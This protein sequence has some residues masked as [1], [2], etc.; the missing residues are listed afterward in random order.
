MKKFLL[1]ITMFLCM[2]PTVFG[3][4]Y[5]STVEY[6]SYSLSE[7]S[8]VLSLLTDMD[9]DLSEYSNTSELNSYILNE[10]HG[11]FIISYRPSATSDDVFP[12]FLFNT[13]GKTNS[14]A[15]WQY[16]NYYDIQVLMPYFN[17][18][19]NKMYVIDYKNNKVDI[20]QYPANYFDE[21][22]IN[23]YS[24]VG[25]KLKLS[26]SGV[27]SDEF[28]S[29]DYQSRMFFDF[30][31]WYSGAWYGVENATS[32][33][34]SPTTS[35]PLNGK[36]IEPEP[37]FTPDTI[38][39]A[40]GYL[41]SPSAPAGDIEVNLDYKE[42]NQ[43]IHGEHFIGSALQSTFVFYYYSGDD[44]ISFNDYVTRNA[45]LN[46]DYGTWYDFYI[47]PQ[48]LEYLPNN[49]N[50]Y[51][52]IYATLGEN[53]ATVVK[54]F[55]AFHTVDN[56]SGGTG[57]DTE[58]GDTDENIQENIQNGIVQGN[59][60]YWGSSGDLTGEKQEELISGKVDELTEQISG[61]LAENEIF[62]ILQKYENKIFGGF[63]GE[64]DFKIEWNDIS[65]MGAVLIPKG[66]INFSQMCREN[67]TLGNVKTTINIILGFF[68]LSNCVIYLYNLLLATLGIDNPYLYETPPE[69]VETVTFD[70]NMNTG[71]T[72][73]TQTTKKR[74]GTTFRLRRKL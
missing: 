23:I 46:T 66:E 70:T 20:V 53:T 40:Y 3:A 21:Q 29:V 33:S 37:E 44:I 14:P 59:T 45:Y 30:V 67:E 13:N 72:M 61:D 4:D 11:K 57:G 41:W 1:M 42:Q 9:I 24:P 54:D 56:S 26:T 50:F 64:E 22:N 74:D 71:E 49:T 8:T 51:L 18:F 73:M 65:Y 25:E 32:S 12:A 63:T 68:L 52:N 31:N 5:S 2:T 27:T 15:Q 10:N 16:R 43:L 6:R 47:E 48:N 28:F 39:S 55:L 7:M 19:L 62:G 69:Q 17:Y 60:E 58:S 34:Y 38:D 36:V 35:E